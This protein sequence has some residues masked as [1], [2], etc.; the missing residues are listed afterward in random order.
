MPIKVVTE[1]ELIE[2][3]EW[4]AGLFEPRGY[5]LASPHSGKR[6]NIDKRCFAKCQWECQGCPF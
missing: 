6:P 2:Q 1:Q 3:M 4:I 5:N